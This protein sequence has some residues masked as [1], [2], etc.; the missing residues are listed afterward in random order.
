[1]FLLLLLVAHAS[2]QLA[3]ECLEQ[4]F[5]ANGRVTGQNID[6]NYE[7]SQLLT[8]GGATQLK[9]QFFVPKR[10]VAQYEANAFAITFNR[11]LDITTPTNHVGEEAWKNDVT[12][13]VD[14]ANTDQSACYSNRYD[15]YTYCKNPVAGLWTIEDNADNACVSDVYATIPWA[16]VMSTAFTG[17]Q[18]KANGDFTEV[19]L[20]ATVETW[21]HFV[22]GDAANYL[23][24][25]TGAEQWQNTDI[26]DGDTNRAGEYGGDGGWRGVG[27]PGFDGNF[28]PI[29]IDDERYTLYQIPFILRFPRTVVVETSFRVSSPITVLTGILGQDVITVDMNPTADGVF[30]VLEA[31]L[32]TQVQY[33]F[34]IRS[35]E[36]DVAPMTVV[37]GSD[38][39]G[40]GT[41]AAS[42]EFVEFDDESGCGG[43]SEGEVCEQTF[44]VRITPAAGSPCT[45]AGDYFFEFW[46]ECVMGGE[47]GTNGCSLDDNLGSADSVQ[48]LERR[49]TSNAY[50][51]TAI[52]IAHQPFCPLLMDE[53]R[54]VG[55]LRVFHDEAFETE[56]TQTQVV[57]GPNTSGSVFTNDRLYFEASYRTAS[58]EATSFTDF[59]ENDF[60]GSVVGDDSIIDYVRSTKIF[61]DVTIG[62]DKDGDATEAFS[63]SDWDSNFQFAL[64]GS[65]IPGTDIS[66]SDIT[67]TTGSGSTAVYQIVLCEVDPIDAEY[68]QFSKDKPVDC[69]TAQNAIAND[70]LDFTKMIRSSTGSSNTIDENEV[71]F[72]MRMD[73]RIIPLKPK[74]TDGSFVKVTVESE[75]YYKGNRHP[76]RRLLQ[77]DEGASTN[78]Q[79]HSMSTA[80]RV[81]SGG[82][83]AMCNMGEDTTEAKLELELTFTEAEAMPTAASSLDW[84]SRLGLQLET[85]LETRDAV[86]VVRM[87]QCNGRG[88]STI[89]YEGRRAQRR[90]LDGEATHLKVYL[91]VAS[92]AE[93]SA[94]RTMN[95]LQ[96]NIV[97]SRS[98]MNTRV[99]AFTQASVTSMRVPGC[100]EDTTTELRAPPRATEERE[101]RETL[102]DESSAFAVSSLVATLVGLWSLF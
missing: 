34:G 30:A 88:C 91:A 48:S 72:Q 95:T 68:I 54:V 12:I 92:T 69:F 99:S 42:V 22:E 17:T 79:N 47:G 21:T 35:P 5:L 90:R 40:G 9:V 41:H 63:T 45:V 25:M 44:K 8:D 19:F 36:D 85:Y 77:V 100:G 101:I 13:F 81:Y 37:V 32:T 29:P 27:V 64:G 57:S 6:M 16:D 51:S 73:E 60:D 26:T 65:R 10:Y 59:E 52:S 55:D 14:Q 15:N 53:V 56:I 80:Y 71:A 66:G 61:M 102:A 97:N 46:A 84:A 62:E 86:S 3:T 38:R 83:L 74:A 70:F 67:V 28:G 75:V 33:P 82:N 58:N 18:V 94:G 89:Y 96:A 24:S 76:T 39:N 11:D 98:D 49:R 78:R 23:G 20:T 43:L 87:E 1:M 2:A 4:E 7:A 93:H 31:T 50:F